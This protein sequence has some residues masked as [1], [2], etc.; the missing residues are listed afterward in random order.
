MEASGQRRVGKAESLEA[1]GLLVVEVLLMQTL[2]FCLQSSYI[3][4]IFLTASQ[5]TM[6]NVR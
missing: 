2:V 3:D 4:D 5:M 6:C 1:A